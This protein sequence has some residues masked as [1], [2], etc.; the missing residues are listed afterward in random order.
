MKCGHCK[1]RHATVA[2]VRA[3]AADA[4]DSRTLPYLPTAE[5]VRNISAVEA[6]G[7][8]R[9][10]FTQTVLLESADAAWVEQQQRDYAANGWSSADR[11][12]SE[13]LRRESKIHITEAG[14][15][16]D[17]KTLEVFK[18]QV[19]VHGSGQLYAKRMFQLDEPKPLARG[20]MKVFDF[21]YARGAVNTIR[22]EWRLTLADAKEFGDLYGCC[23][24]CGK[25]LT[26]E[27]SIEHG[28]GD[29]C[30]GHA[31]AEGLI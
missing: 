6:A 19:A 20:G 5:E 27:T 1:E 25:T 24:R 9:P 26:K 8:V 12:R 14:M 18:V 22:P 28:M 10:A 2:E 16:R 7:L 3:C 13:E 23:M 4:I 31:S 11:E 21:V 30:Y 29:T 15:Y 17:P